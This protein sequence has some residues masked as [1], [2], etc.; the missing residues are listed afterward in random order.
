MLL[1]RDEKHMLTPEE[2]R[3]RTRKRRRFIFAIAIVLVLGVA[4]FFIA[5]PT[6]NA[7]KGWQAR[8]HA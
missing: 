5:R 3:L 8:R 1:T 6:R 7:I 4:A 2:L